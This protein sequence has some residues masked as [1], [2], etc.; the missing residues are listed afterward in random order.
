MTSWLI[1]R[2]VG[3]DRASLF[4]AGTPVYPDA[5]PPITVYNFP[6]STTV[7]IGSA[8]CA[9]LRS[10]S[11]FYKIKPH[12]VLPGSCEFDMTYG[13]GQFISVRALL[14]G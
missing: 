8:T 7:T 14:G 5:Q 3:T 10:Q 2:P 6:N 4:Y 13:G 9:E 11:G 1:T 12:P